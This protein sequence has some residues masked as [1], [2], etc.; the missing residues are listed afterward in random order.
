MLIHKIFV[1]QYQIQRN[2]Q[3]I[4]NLHLK[5]A[6]TV[7]VISEGQWVSKLKVMVKR[8]YLTQMIRGILTNQMLTPV[9]FMEFLSAYSYFSEY[10]LKNYTGSSLLLLYS[11][12]SIMQIKEESTAIGHVIL[13]IS[14]EQFI[15]KKGRLTK[16]K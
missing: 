5:N 2:T 14:K 4:R 10:L 15:R 13:A 12:C 3:M 16:Y 1:I 11:F 7:C 8:I 9:Q 6:F